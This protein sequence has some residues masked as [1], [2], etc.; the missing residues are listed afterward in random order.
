MSGGVRNRFDMTGFQRAD[1]R[2]A[3]PAKVL[4]ASDVVKSYEVNSILLLLLF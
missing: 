2:G 4:Y 1:L 3:V